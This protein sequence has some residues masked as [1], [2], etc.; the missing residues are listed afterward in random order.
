MQSARSRRVALRQSWTSV[1]QPGRVKQTRPH[2]AG[3]AGEQPRTW[4]RFTFSNGL[5]PHRWNRLSLRE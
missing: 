3:V 2:V 5:V 1:A 4:D